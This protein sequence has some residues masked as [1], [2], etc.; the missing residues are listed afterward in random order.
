MR[1]R[2]EMAK[3]LNSDQCREI[4]GLTTDEFAELV[5]GPYG[6]P[7]IRI[8]PALRFDLEA[9]EKWL[10]GA[11]SEA[12]QEVNSAPPRPESP[13]AQYI[14]PE[15]VAPGPIE[16]PKVQANRGDFPQPVSVYDESGAPRADASNKDE[17]I[18][19]ANR[20]TRGIPSQDKP[21]LRP[22]SQEYPDPTLGW[23]PEKLGG[24]GIP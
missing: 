1:G 21:Y 4:L 22:T 2:S 17:I 12:K 24:N 14:G 7:I 11:L 18:A 10:A 5:E 20:D 8:G 13:P 23:E 15:S 6:L 9:I 16:L 3:L 19:A